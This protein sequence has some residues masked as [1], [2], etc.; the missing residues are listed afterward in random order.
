MVSHNTGQPGYTTYIVE[1][2][3]M[4]NDVEA[5]LGVDA[6]SLSSTSVASSLV[7]GQVI[8][9]TTATSSGGGLGVDCNLFRW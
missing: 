2:Q 8:N 3:Q 9:L 7:S 5:S 1:E 6:Y 4:M